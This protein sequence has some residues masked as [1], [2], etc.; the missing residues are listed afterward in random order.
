MQD[1][2]SWQKHFIGK[3]TYKS[4]LLW[5][6]YWCISLLAKSQQSWNYYIS[7]ILLFCSI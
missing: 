3:A 1:L 5:F 4:I 6:I 2:Y 7:I